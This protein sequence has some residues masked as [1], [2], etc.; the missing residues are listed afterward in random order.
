MSQMPVTLN[1]ELRNCPTWKKLNDA[2]E[3]LAGAEPYRCLFRGHRNASWHLAPTIERACKPGTIYKAERYFLDEFRSKAHL[4]TSSLPATADILGW[5]SAMQHYRVPTRLLDWSYSAYVALYFAVERPS[6]EKRC[7]IWAINQA[8]L[9][10]TSDAASMAVFG[11]SLSDYVAEPERFNPKVGAFN[12]STG[13]VAPTLPRFHVSRLS[14]QQGCFLFNANPLIEFEESLAYMMKGQTGWLSC[15][16]FPSG[17]RT[18][19]L[20]RLMHMNIH[21]ASLFPDLEGL[22]RF[23]TLKNELFPGGDVSGRRHR[24]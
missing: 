14:S 1:P 9:I 16:T 17:L 24:G 2:I 19:C 21:P 12:D 22:G 4:H 8:K 20:K 10:Q 5:L 18:E 13:L 7:A 11:V 15:I 6:D 23:L 3:S